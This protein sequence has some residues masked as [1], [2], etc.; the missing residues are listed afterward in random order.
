MVGELCA[1]W[2]DEITSAS[3]ACV[4]EVGPTEDVD[5]RGDPS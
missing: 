3:R 2:K 4:R 1:L 5:E